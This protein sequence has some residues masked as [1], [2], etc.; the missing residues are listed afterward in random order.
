MIPALRNW[1]VSPEPG[2]TTTAIVSQSSSTSVSDW[3]T[4]TVSTTTTS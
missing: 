3:P 1:S 2:C 4:P